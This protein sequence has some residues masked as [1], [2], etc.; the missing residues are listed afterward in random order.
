MRIVLTADH[1]GVDLKD[2]LAAWLSEQGHDVL[3]LGT[4]GHESVD[5]PRYG[6]ILAEALADG[7]AIEFCWEGMVSRSSIGLAAAMWRSALFGGR[8]WGR[9]SLTEFPM[10]FTT[11][12][13][14]RQPFDHILLPSERQT[15][16]QC[17]QNLTFRTIATAAGCRGS[18]V[19]RP[20]ALRPRSPGL[21]SSRGRP[22]RRN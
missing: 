15:G 6:V 10:S 11:L 21:S 5:Y 19:R 22:S 18:R 17:K 1:A 12:R 16:R 9:V 3:D 4:H 2:E 8:S 20:P 13:V 14:L 7:R